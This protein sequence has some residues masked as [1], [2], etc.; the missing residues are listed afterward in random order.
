MKV[1]IQ[2]LYPEPQLAW[3]QRRHKPALEA[4]DGVTD[5]RL[6]WFD[7]HKQDRLIQA[8]T[9]FESAEALAAYRANKVVSGP[10][11]EDAVSHGLITEWVGTLTPILDS[12]ESSSPPNLEAIDGGSPELR[13]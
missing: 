4:V 11:S 7:R 10:I 12:E 13:G 1:S 5:V 2:A 8:T 9:E 6:A 3:L